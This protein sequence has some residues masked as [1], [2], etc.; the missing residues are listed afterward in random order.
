MSQIINLNKARKTK[1]RAQARIQAAEN[2]V[3]HGLTKA[4]RDLA[5]ADA[6]KATRKLDG[7]RLDD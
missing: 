7:S 4:E 5:K 3:R 1:A 2:R 6:A